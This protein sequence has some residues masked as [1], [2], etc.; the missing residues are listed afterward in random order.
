MGENQRFPSKESLKI[1]PKRSIL[2]S[3]T[4]IKSPSNVVVIT[5]DVK[6]LR[7]NPGYSNLDIFT[8]DE[9]QMAT[10]LFRPDQVL[11]ETGFGVVYKGL[12]D[13]NVKIGYAKTQVAIKEL[14]LEGIQRDREW[15]SPV[16]MYAH[17]NDRIEDKEKMNCV[18]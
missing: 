18:S 10:K 3:T 8:Y 14:D 6:D 12:I 4:I 13:N 17:M 7:Q 2:E 16:L 9:M 15:L 11:G 1:P 5:K